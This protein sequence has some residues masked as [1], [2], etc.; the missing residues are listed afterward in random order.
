MDS[1]NKDADEQRV[2][3]AWRQLAMRRGDEYAAELRLIL[4]N[5]LENC[6][7][8]NFLEKDE[9]PAGYVK[10][11][12]EHYDRWHQHVTRVQDEQD[13]EAWREL[14]TQFQKWAYNFL[15]R[16]EFSHDPQELME[17]AQICATEAALTLLS[18]RFP[19][20][21]HF[22]RWS[23]TILQYMC[24]RH[25]SQQWN[26]QQQFQETMV[27]LD[28]YEDWI[29]NIAN[30]QSSKQIGLNNLRRDLLNAIGRLNSKK[31]QKFLILYYF[32]QNS[33]A[34]IAEKMNTSKNSL[35]KLHSDALK[36]LRNVWSGEGDDE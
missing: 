32:E 36:E 8:Q 3:E 27:S 31:R 5:S 19:Y 25:L 1:A 9:T 34:E 14:F 6:R 17:H 24:L 12:E 29:R 13:P 15:R 26:R 16:K 7:I 11:V 35:Y 22:G 18:T 23:Y 30:P 20:D 33:F 2:W 4:T 10:R 28:E 21:V